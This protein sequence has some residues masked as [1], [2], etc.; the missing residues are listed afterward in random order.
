MERIIE[1][2]ADGSATLFVPELNEHYHSVKGALTESSHIFID[3]GLKASASP[4]VSLG[5]SEAYL[6]IGY[7]GFERSW[8]DRLMNNTPHI[9]VFDTS[10]GVDLIFES[11]F[12]HGDHRHEGGVEP[13]IWNSTAN[14][15]IIAGNTFKALTVLDKENEAYYKARYDSLC[16]R[17]E[18][19]DSLIRQTLSVPG[20]DRAFIIYHPA[21]SYF[22]RDYGLHQISIE[23]GGKEPSPAHL[24]G[25]MDLCKNEWVIIGPNGGGKT[26]LIKC[27]LG[28]LRPTG[29]EIIKYH[30][31]L[32][33]GY[34]PQYNSIDRSFPISVLEVVLSGLSSKKSLTGRFNDRHREKARQVIH[35]M[36][37]EG[38]EHRAIGQLSGEVMQGGVFAQSSFLSQGTIVSLHREARFPQVRKTSFPRIRL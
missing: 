34:L 3:M 12:D 32:T 36:G 7:I 2:T 1:Y 25:L 11:A 31:P 33:T 27:I 28:L 21:L 30:E 19:T 22:A 13:H 23:E 9:Q 26:T 5:E 37:L 18:Q 15:L 17:I 10:T 8:M 16:Q 35:R 24:K 38:L 20:A 29:G 4:L 6:R 14:A